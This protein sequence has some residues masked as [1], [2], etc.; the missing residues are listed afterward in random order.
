MRGTLKL[1]IHI[2]QLNA[3]V[4]VN[5]TRV[6][7][8]AELIIDDKSEHCIPFILERI[9]D[10]RKAYQNAGKDAPPFFIGLNGVQGAVKT[11]LVGLLRS[12]RH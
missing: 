4:V 7:D 10:H 11:T 1:D 6:V 5:Y 8:M 2:R 12:L 3:T 9:Q